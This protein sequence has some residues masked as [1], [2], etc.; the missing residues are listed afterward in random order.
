M[1][2]R[3]RVWLSLLAVAILAAAIFAGGGRPP[4]GPPAAPPARRG[5]LPP[6]SDR[7]P[8]PPADQISFAPFAVTDVG[9]GQHRFYEHFSRGAAG[10]AGASGEPYR[11]WLGGRGGGA[12]AG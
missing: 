8:D 3:G 7:G 4:G 10:L 5:G 6:P 9:A 12:L 1:P 11:V 2:M